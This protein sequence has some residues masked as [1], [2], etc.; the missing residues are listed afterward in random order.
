MGCSLET[1]LH[2]YLEEIVLNRTYYRPKRVLSSF[3]S[4]VSRLYWPE[5]WVDLVIVDRARMLRTAIHHFVFNLRTPM[6]R[7]P[8]RDST[9]L[10]LWSWFLFSLSRPQ[11]AIFYLWL[12]FCNT[13]CLLFY[14]PS[15]V[16]GDYFSSN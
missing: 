1:P 7:L 12:H 6:P 2:G 5:S 10:A 4:R 8:L 9:G 16:A 11:L 15:F 13:Y 14:F 3:A